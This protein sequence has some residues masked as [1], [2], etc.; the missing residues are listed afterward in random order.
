MLLSPWKRNTA[1]LMSL[2]KSKAQL[3]LQAG[4]KWTMS[5][6][7]CFRS[8]MEFVKRTIR[9]IR[10]D[11]KGVA[12]F[13]EKLQLEHLRWKYSPSDNSLYLDADLEIT[14]VAGEKNELAPIQLLEREMVS[15]RG[16]IKDS[17]NNPIWAEVVFVD[18]RMTIFVF[19]RCGIMMSLVFQMG[20]L[21][22]D[23]SRKLQNFGRK[24]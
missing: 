14:I 1:C 3:R 20:I 12:R 16:T 9:C 8:W 4:R 23:S 17:S 13:E 22:K 15:V 5:F 2:L 19:G 10:L 7:I 18:P 21:L 24:I 6:S 11:W